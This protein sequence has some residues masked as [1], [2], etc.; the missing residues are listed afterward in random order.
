MLFYAGGAIM[1]FVYEQASTFF[2]NIGIW[3]TITLLLLHVIIK[4][5]YVY[6]DYFSLH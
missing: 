3:H 4:Y 6:A 2:M 1:M 5:N